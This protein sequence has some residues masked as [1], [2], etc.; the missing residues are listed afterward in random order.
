ME[1]GR[2]GQGGYP[3]KVVGGELSTF[4]G[5]IVGGNEI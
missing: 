2:E 5:T 4:L 1:E 3:Y